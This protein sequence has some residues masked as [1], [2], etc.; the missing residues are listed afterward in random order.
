MDGSEVRNGSGHQHG[1]QNF[2]DVQLDME[3][4]K[5]LYIPKSDGGRTLIRRRRASS[6][7]RSSSKRKIDHEDLNE[8]MLQDDNHLLPSLRFTRKHRTK[9][10]K[11]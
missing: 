9:S 7:K 2:S 4:M 10:L 8:L 3:N 11:G 1:S 6:K 5:T